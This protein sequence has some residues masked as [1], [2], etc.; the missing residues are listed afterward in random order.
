MPSLPFTPPLVQLHD[1]LV[2][3]NPIIWSNDDFNDLAGDVPLD[4][5]LREM[6]TAGFSGSE[7]GHAYPRTPGPL[8]DALGRHDLRLV[9]G[10]HSTYL[11]SRELAEEE[12]SFRAHSNLLKALGARV[13]IVAECTRC[14]HGDRDT[15]L[16]FGDKLAPRLSEAEWPRLLAGLKH[17]A[18]LAVAEDM[19]VVYHHHMGTVIQNETDL[20]RLLAGVPELRL[21]LDAGHLAFAGIDPVAVARRYAA[22]IAHVHLKSVRPEVAERVRREGWS[23]YRAVVNGVFTVAGDGCVDY[24]AIFALLAGADYR[25]WLVVEAEEDPVKV[26]ALPKATRARDY[27]RQQTGV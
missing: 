7:L 8:A 9:S 17:L 2:G 4:T 21:L 22:R 5:I 18:A 11:V 3:A 23:F 24:P 13:V 19:Q 25:G 16:G 14:I 12:R 6:R 15:A 26:P 20:H 1:C 27:V 10:W